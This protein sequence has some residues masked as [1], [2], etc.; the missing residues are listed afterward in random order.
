MKVGSLPRAQLVLL[1]AGMRLAGKAGEA[2][3][4]EREEEAP[5]SKEGFGWRLP[6]AGL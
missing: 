6:A 3:R 1:L 5:S 2:A 4:V